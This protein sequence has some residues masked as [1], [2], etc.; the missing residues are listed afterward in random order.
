M[1]IWTDAAS[2]STWAPA[3]ISLP[4]SGTVPFR[5]STTAT[6]VTALA[7]A[8]SLDKKDMLG[9]AMGSSEAAGFLNRV[10]HITGWLN[11]LAFAPVD[12]N[13]RAPSDEWSG[14]QGVGVMYFSQQADNHLAPRAG[15]VFPPEMGLP[16]RLERVQEQVNKED[17]S[18]C[19]IFET[20]GVYL[21]YTLPYYT[22]FYDYGN[23]LLLGRV[24]SGRGAKSFSTKRMRCSKKSFPNGMK[25]LHYMCRMSKA[26]G[27][28][29][30]WPRRVY[31][32]CR[33]NSR[34]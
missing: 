8:L 20:I 19:R 17:P 23:L 2:V 7:G 29:K 13:P 5:S 27:L 6:S 12:F 9:I 10:G 3:I 33:P 34:I 30:P 4:K 11:E 21:G 24:T 31:P 1:V 25:N 26:G 22:L 16:E 28:A 32:R 18:A 15:M 14:D